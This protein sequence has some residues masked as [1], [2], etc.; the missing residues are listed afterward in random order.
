MKPQALFSLAAAIGL[1]AFSTPAF[2]DIT[3]LTTAE[4]FDPDR[5][6]E[7][8]QADGTS[9]YTNK[10][11]PGCKL[12]PLKPLSVVPSLDNMP[13]YR[14][15]QGTAHHPHVPDHSWRNRIEMSNGEPQTPDWAADWHAGIAPSGSVLARVCSMYGE[16]LN[17]NQKT[18]GGVFFG[19]DPSYGGDLSAQNQRG[20][21][22]SYYDNARYLA[23]SKIF[24]GGFVPIGCP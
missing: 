14:P 15:I 7:C 21:S 11:R 23:L 17:I 24:G 3:A 5:M 4:N 2:S 12:M 19:S 16:W 10:D 9:L 18:R 22:Y 20:T 13:T 1:A 8:T 6:W